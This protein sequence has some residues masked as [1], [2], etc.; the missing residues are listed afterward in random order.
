MR[1]RRQPRTL[2]IPVL[3]GDITDAVLDQ[4]AD[5]ARGRGARL[6]ILHLATGPRLA[7]DEAERVGGAGRRTPRWRLLAAAAPHGHL[8]VETMQGDPVRTV[9]SEL[10]RF[11]RAIVMIGAPDGRE[12]HATW[13]RGVVDELARA[14]PGRARVV[15][16][17]APVAPRA[18]MFTSH[19]YREPSPC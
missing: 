15:G 11:P 18:P 4:A 3:G 10:A 6:V 16:N 1:A 13:A 7:R 17:P 19:A 8:F 5:E 14:L 9:V 2:V 12:P